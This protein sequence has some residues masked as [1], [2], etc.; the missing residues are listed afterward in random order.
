MHPGS[1]Q[2]SY[3]KFTYSHALEP[4]VELKHAYSWGAHLNTFTVVLAFH[5]IPDPLWIKCFLKW[6]LPEQTRNH[7]FSWSTYLYEN[8]KSYAMYWIVFHQGI[9]LFPKT[10]LFYPQWLP[11]RNVALH[12]SCKSTSTMPAAQHCIFRQ[13]CLYNRKSITIKWFSSHHLCCEL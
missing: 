7:N 2:I 4:R 5:S 11:G 3:Y 9:C 6:F 13:H 12:Q 1:V 10:C 8:C